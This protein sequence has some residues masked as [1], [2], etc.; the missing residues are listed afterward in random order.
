LSAE[1]VLEGGKVPLC[2]GPSDVVVR[3]RT[4]KEIVAGEYAEVWE[5]A[6]C[7]HGL[8][9]VGSDVAAQ[10]S[11]VDKIWEGEGRERGGSLSD[12][13]DIVPGHK[14]EVCEA[15][16]K[17]TKLTESG[18]SALVRPDI[19][20]KSLTSKITPKSWRLRRCGS[21]LTAREILAFTS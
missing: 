6:S 2:F 18:K 11:E 17:W 4:R 7:E 21:A 1:V 12:E 8:D 19:A 14:L 16:D 10:E 9:D 13:S 20:S 15:D 5:N 3:S